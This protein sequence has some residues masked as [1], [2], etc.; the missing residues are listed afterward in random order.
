MQLKIEISAAT[1]KRLLVLGFGLLVAFTV[2][3]VGAVPVNFQSQQVLTAKQ[4]NDNFASVES[5]LAVITDWQSYPC[6][7]SVGAV[8]IN[9]ASAGTTCFYRRVG[10]S[11]EVHVGTLLPQDVPTTVSGMLT[12]SLPAGVVWDSQKGSRGNRGPGAAG[13][14]TADNH[15]CTFNVTG[16]G[17]SLYAYCNGDVAGA[18]T[19]LRAGYPSTWGPGFGV[20]FS[21]SF[22]VVGWTS[23]TPAP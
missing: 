18:A 2:A 23:T 9:A 3:D 6:A 8:T 14:T 20:E 1:T 17:M 11:A 10:D 12:W 22:P 21:A 5:R 16:D 7:L 4:L 19:L 13:T 15:V